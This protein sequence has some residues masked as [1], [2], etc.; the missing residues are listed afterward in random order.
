MQK[1]SPSNVLQTLILSE[2]QILNKSVT[3]YYSSL[4]ATKSQCSKKN[5]GVLEPFENIKS[6]SLVP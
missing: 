1:Y 3:F 4:L 2:N 5:C 6:T